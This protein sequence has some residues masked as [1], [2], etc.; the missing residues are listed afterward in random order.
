VQDAFLEKLSSGALNLKVFGTRK[1]N[2]LSEIVKI[3]YS[4]IVLMII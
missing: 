4:G 1:P 3:Y 2:G